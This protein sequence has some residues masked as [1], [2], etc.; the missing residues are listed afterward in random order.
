MQEFHPSPIK[1]KNEDVGQTFFVSFLPS[2]S[3]LPTPAALLQSGQAAHCPHT[4]LTHCRLQ[5]ALSHPFLPVR[6]PHPEASSALPWLITAGDVGPATHTVQGQPCAICQPRGAQPFF[7]AIAPDWPA[8]APLCL[9]L[10]AS[11]LAQQFTHQPTA[12]ELP[13]R[14]HCIVQ[15]FAL[16]PVSRARARGRPLL[17]RGTVRFLWSSSHFL[18]PVFPIT[19]YSHLGTRV[20]LMDRFLSLLPLAGQGQG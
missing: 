16:A 6:F 5:L 9:S 1:P 20:L 11:L 7:P 12:T 2:L 8:I 17:C 13:G 10:P 14:V 3:V 18:V 4:P 15:C 19:G